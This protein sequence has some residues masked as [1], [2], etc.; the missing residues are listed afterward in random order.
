MYGL[1]ANLGYL[2]QNIAKIVYNIFKVEMLTPFDHK[3]SDLYKYIALL[4][5]NLVSMLELN[6]ENVKLSQGDNTNFF[7]LSLSRQAWT[8]VQEKKNKDSNSKQYPIRNCTHKRVL[9]HKRRP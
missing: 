6:K 9:V 4:S 5:Q 3:G 7:E 1:A 8:Q 2:L